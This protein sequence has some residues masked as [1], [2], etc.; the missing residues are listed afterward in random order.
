METKKQNY[1]FNKGYI[2]LFLALILGSLRPVL[3]EIGVTGLSTPIRVT[4]LSAIIAG[5]IAFIFNRP[6]LKIFN[7]FKYYIPGLLLLLNTILTA[8]ALKYTNLITVITIISLTP[9]VVAFHKLILEKS[10]KNI[11]WF[12]AGF[13]F[14]FI[15]ILQVIEITSFEDFQLN[16][17]GIVLS[18]L[19]VIVSDAYRVFIEKKAL[20]VISKKLSPI[21]VMTGGLFSLAYIPFDPMMF[22]NTNFKFWIVIVLLAI[23]ITYSNLLF[24]KA[25][26]MV[27]AL[28]TSLVYIMQPAIVVILGILFIDEPFK[29]NY[30]TGISLIILGLFIFKF[31]SIHI[32]LKQKINLYKTKL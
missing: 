28:T 17:L 23:S 5:L 11:G 16:L 12:F 27:G 31:P 20:R 29:M 15:G 26:K 18:I 32:R 10:T 24:I 13:V 4:V 14:A 9:I 1:S 21:I 6:N 25:L 8:Y 19:V 7:K 22:T 30:L 3:I 2:S